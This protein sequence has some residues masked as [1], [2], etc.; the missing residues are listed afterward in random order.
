MATVF[1]QMIGRVFLVH[2]TFSLHSVILGYS[3]ASLIP[4]SL[5]VTVVRLS[6]FFADLLKILGILWAT[7]SAFISYLQVSAVI[8]EVK[9][10]RR[11]LLMMPLLLMHVYLISLLPRL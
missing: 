4:I 11:Y 3:V 2:S 7:T 1:Q 6:N 5:L 9:E 10:S 8:P